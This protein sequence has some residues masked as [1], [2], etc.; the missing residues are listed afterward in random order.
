MAVAATSGGLPNAINASASAAASSAAKPNCFAVPPIR[1]IAAT[2]SFSRAAVLLPK[3][4]MASPSFS[5]SPI[6][7]WNTLAIVAAALPASS[8]VMPKATD[9]LDAMAVNSDNFSIGMPSCPPAAARSAISA[10]EM[11]NSALIF[12]SSSESWAYCSSVPSATF[13]TPAIAVSNF[14]ASLAANAKPPALP[15]KP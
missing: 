3:T 1:A 12:F 7:S 11:P 8:A 5:T 9:I 15:T 10:A 14:I 13:F 4:L 6:G 2:M